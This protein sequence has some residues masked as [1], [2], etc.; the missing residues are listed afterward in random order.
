MADAGV[1]RGV[2]LRASESLLGR[3]WKLLGS[4][5]EP[6]GIIFD[7]FGASFGAPRPGRERKGRKSENHGFP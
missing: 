3:P 2:V 5:G 1:M 6:L 4:Y 7:A